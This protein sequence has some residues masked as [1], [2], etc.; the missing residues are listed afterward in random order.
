M[1]DYPESNSQ[2]WRQLC[3]AA[4]GE[5]DPKKLSRLIEQLLE[6]TGE[7]EFPAPSPAQ[8]IISVSTGT[9]SAG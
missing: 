7:K 9:T 5:A 6:A 4:V 8:T 2:D 1:T 3:A